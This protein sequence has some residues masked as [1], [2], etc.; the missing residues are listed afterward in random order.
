MWVNQAGNGFADPVTI[1]GTPQAAGASLRL[2][3]IDGTGTAGVLWTYDLG[4][5]RGSATSSST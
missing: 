4:P 5:V 1:R 2:A 3:D